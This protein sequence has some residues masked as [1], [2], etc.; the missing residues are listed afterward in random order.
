MDEDFRTTVPSVF[1]AGD[2]VG[3]PALASVSMEQGRVA[4][5]R[6]FGFAYKEKVAPIFPYGIYTI[7]EVSAIGEN[8]QTASEKGI[9]YVTGSAL[10]VN[11]PRGRIT[12]DLE[13]MT[14]LVVCRNTRRVIGVHVIGE[15][16]S[17]LVHIGQ[18]VMHFNGPVDA[19]IEM[20][21]NYPTL[22]DSFKYAA[23]DALGKL[24]T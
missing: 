21:F 14:K 13:G 23:Y 8:E 4:A 12:G 9:D 6:M 24:N 2:V 18:A 17:E 16:A 11:N 10:Y 22:A 1:A 5:C 15:R 20:V 19:F 3:F 7:P